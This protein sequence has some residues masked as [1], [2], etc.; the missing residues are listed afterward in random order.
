MGQSFSVTIRSRDVRTLASSVAYNV[1][2]AWRGSG[3]TNVRAGVV[4]SKFVLPFLREYCRY[5]AKP[6]VV[7][8]SIPRTSTFLF[9]RILLYFVFHSFDFDF[10]VLFR[11]VGGQSQIM[12]LAIFWRGVCGV[13]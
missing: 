4:A 8:S 5:L 7:S 10:T 3:F 1:P 11:V 12:A 13:V 9:N 6:P 2:A